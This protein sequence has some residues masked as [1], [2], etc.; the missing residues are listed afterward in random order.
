[1]VYQRQKF[2]RVVYLVAWK[3]EA[4][5]AARFSLS[6]PTGQRQWNGLLR[7]CKLNVSIQ[8]RLYTGNHRGSGNYHTINSRAVIIHY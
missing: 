7:G 5:I 4:V 6:F 8:L 3:L 2:S 1:M